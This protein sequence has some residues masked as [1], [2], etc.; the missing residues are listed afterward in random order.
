MKSKVEEKQ[1]N[2][3]DKNGPSFDQT[4]TFLQIPVAI[5]DKVLSFI[6]SIY[7]HDDN[8]NKPDDFNTPFQSQGCFFVISLEKI[9]N[10]IKNLEKAL[11]YKDDELEKIKTEI[12]FSLE[13]LKG[14]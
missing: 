5:K 3:I 11:S 9:E 1:R 13:I 12:K 2:S 7:L 8:I 4:M 6:N 10:L 14:E